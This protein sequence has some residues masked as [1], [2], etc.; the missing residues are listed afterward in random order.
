MFQGTFNIQ[1]PFVSEIMNNIKML[2]KVLKQSKYELILSSQTWIFSWAYY[3]K[4]DIVYNTYLWYKKYLN[5]FIKSVT[6]KSRQDGQ[7]YSCFLL[8]TSFSSIPMHVKWYHWQQRL[9]CI[10]NVLIKLKKFSWITY[11]D[12]IVLRKR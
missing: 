5:T 11:N 8:G 7:K 4:I 10:M 9:H 1:Y 2:H 12:F 6:V 3:V